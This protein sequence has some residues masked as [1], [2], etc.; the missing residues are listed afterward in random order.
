MA[1]WLLAVLFAWICNV[2]FNIAATDPIAPSPW[3]LADVPLNVSIRSALNTA[4]DLLLTYV[5]GSGGGRINATS[6][7]MNIILG[8]YQLSPYESEETASPATFRFHGYED[9]E[10]R[11]ERADS[12]NPFI[13]RYMVVALYTGLQIVVSRGFYSGT[14]AMWLQRPGEDRLVGKMVFSERE[15]PR[16]NHYVTNANNNQVTTKAIDYMD[17]KHY[18]PTYNFY[19]LPDEAS[20]VNSGTPVGTYKYKLYYNFS[21][22]PIAISSYL[23]TIAYGIFYFALEDAARRITQR[24]QIDDDET[25]AGTHLL[26]T[27]YWYPRRTE[28]PYF[29]GHYAARALKDLAKVALASRRFFAVEAVVEMEQ[30]TPVGFLNLSKLPDAVVD[31]IQLQPS[32][33]L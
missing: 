10:I 9:V 1:F 13:R 25:E 32:L 22:T 21:V 30:D 14:W 6:V 28:P 16:I 12:G 8:L 24:S 17:S 20:M 19:T 27:E 33:I 31:H 29:I 11:F 5:T 3:G 4:D 23:L 7:F 2:P 18:K 26:V 15:R